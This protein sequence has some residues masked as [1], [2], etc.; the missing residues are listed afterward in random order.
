MERVGVVVEVTRD[1]AKESVARTDERRDQ[2]VA[3]EVD[4][5]VHR[6]HDYVGVANFS[7]IPVT[8]DAPR[9]H[10]SYLT[11]TADVT[12]LREQGALVTWPGS[13]YLASIS[14]PPLPGARA[15]FMQAF[16]ERHGAPSTLAG[17]AY[18]ALGILQFAA[19]LAPS[20]LDAPRLRLRL[21]TLTFGG[22]VTRYT[23]SFTRHAGF[24]PDDLAYLRWNGQRNAPFLATDPKE[25]A[26]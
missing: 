4:A 6:E 17:T 20:E 23:F 25:D 14:L 24:T 10:L 22:V 15:A 19:A 3:R 18:D 11:E 13:R 1:C 2:V 12:N 26:K 9:V 5:R 21:E 8:F 7:A 16:T